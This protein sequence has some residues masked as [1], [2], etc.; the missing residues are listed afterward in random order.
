MTQDHPS[1]MWT[2]IELT[3]PVE[4]IAMLELALLVAEIPE[5]TNDNESEIDQ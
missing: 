2:A 1:Q 4:A 3:A 5:T